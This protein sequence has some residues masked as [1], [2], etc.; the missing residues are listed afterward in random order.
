MPINQQD[1][2][3]IATQTQKKGWDE[4]I[5]QYSLNQIKKN[6]RIPEDLRIADWIYFLPESSLENVLVIGAGL[7]TTPLALASICQHVTCIDSNESQIDIL[8]RRAQSYSHLRTFLS[9]NW[10][11]INNQSYSLI[12]VQD[13]SLAFQLTHSQTL[14]DLNNQLHQLLSLNGSLQL[15][16]RNKYSIQ[17]LMDRSD[18]IKQ[19]RFYSLNQYRKMFKKSGFSQVSTY[20]PIP[21]FDSIPLFYLPVDYHRALKYFFKVIFPLFEMVSPE[22]TKQYGLQYQVA[23][24]GAN[25]AMFFHLYPLVKYFLSGYLFIATKHA[26]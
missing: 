2:E 19:T 10:A 20:A 1:I 16:L 15:F 3:S 7:G 13:L 8:K 26:R 6:E 11:Q 5:F 24:L 17:Y 25:G 22:V 18:H 4:A 23:K 9:D 21:H 14:H 12:A